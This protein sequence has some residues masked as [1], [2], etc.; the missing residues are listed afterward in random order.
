MNIQYAIND[1]KE[2]G[3]IYSW[4]L[5]KYEQLDLGIRILAKQKCHTDETGKGIFTEDG[6]MLVSPEDFPLYQYKYKKMKL[7]VY[8]RKLAGT[9]S[10]KKRRRGTYTIIKNDVSVQMT[11]HEICHDLNIS[12]DN[13]SIFI[14]RGSIGIRKGTLPAEAKIILDVCREKGYRPSHNLLKR[15]VANKKRKLK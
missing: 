4:T 9:F 8:Y 12:E 15:A 3:S 7:Q 10:V 13:Q 11:Y 5:I 2:E 1:F 14:T 6:K